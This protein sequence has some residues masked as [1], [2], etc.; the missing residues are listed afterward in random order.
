MILSGSERLLIF[1]CEPW[2]TVLLYLAIIFVMLEVS[3]DE[4]IYY[5]IHCTLWMYTKMMNRV[6]SINCKYIE[7]AETSTKQLFSRGK[8]RDEKD[9]VW[10]V[11]YKQFFKRP[12]CLCI[13][14]RIRS[15]V[16][17]CHTHTLLYCCNMQSVN[18][19]WIRVIGNLYQ[20]AE[21]KIRSL[22]IR[23]SMHVSYVYIVRLISHSCVS[24]N[25]V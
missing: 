12:I 5:F 17:M 20:H 25:V 24:L 23:T 8:R 19:F 22:S 15:D 7:H 11:H 16:R 3:Y 9:G 13:V 10:K 6:H 1:W 4:R 14:N 2:W 21:S 18:A